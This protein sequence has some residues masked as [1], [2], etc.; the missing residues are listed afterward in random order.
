MRDL[1]DATERE[2]V[3]INWNAEN[4]ALH[5]LD[6]A[7]PSVTRDNSELRRDFVVGADGYHGSC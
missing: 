1:L 7:A 6:T 2:G 3:A 4:V 5:G